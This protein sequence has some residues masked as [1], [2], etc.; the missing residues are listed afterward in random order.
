MAKMNEMKRIVDVATKVARKV[1][2]AAT[3]LPMRGAIAR[4]AALME[5]SN[6]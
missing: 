3:K 5:L 1:N 2:Q 6:P 4:P